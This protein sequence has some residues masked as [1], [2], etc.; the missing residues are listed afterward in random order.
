MLHQHVNVHDILTML[1][2]FSC[3]D[4]LCMLHQL[5]HVHDMPNILR[6]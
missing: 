1:N 5:I 2:Q 3:N 4:M 6:Y